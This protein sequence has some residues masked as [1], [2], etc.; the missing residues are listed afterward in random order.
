MN[1]ENTG[2]GMIAAA[3]ILAII[4]LTMFFSEVEERQ[5]N[6]NQSP[7]TTRTGEVVEVNLERNRRG[8][9]VAS[10]TINDEPVEFLL[11]TGATDVVVPEPLA[12]RLNLE[13]GRQG[14]AMTANGMVTVYVTHLDRLSIGGIE[15]FDVR[16]SINP[17]MSLPGVLLG[18]SALEQIEFNQQG[19]ELIL[20]QRTNST[21]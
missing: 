8:H 9:Y 20:R 19:D 17:A 5:R 10:G 1:A 13:K 15:L 16:A 18:M 4:L 3:C 21:L 12:E 14:R 7:V 2:R 11:D 6:P